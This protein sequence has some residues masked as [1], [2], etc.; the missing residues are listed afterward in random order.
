MWTTFDDFQ[1]TDWQ[2]VISHSAE[3]STN[4]SYKCK[5][6][7]V[8]RKLNSSGYTKWR[9]VLWAFE[10]AMVMLQEPTEAA[11]T[12]V[13]KNSVKIFKV[14][15]GEATWELMIFRTG[16]CLEGPSRGI[17]P[18]IRSK[19]KSKNAENRHVLHVSSNSNIGERLFIGYKLDL[20]SLET[21]TMIDQNSD[22]QGERHSRLPSD[23]K[24]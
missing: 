17:F 15:A 10:G 20:S 16:R 8:S 2:Q 23:G 19:I 24:A 11:L 3:H 21:V 5:I 9:E 14:T 7:G 13:E 1:E 12:P 22:I 6:C 18:Q 4:R